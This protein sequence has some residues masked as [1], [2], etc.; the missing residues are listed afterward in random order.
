V[1]LFPRFYRAGGSKL[2]AARIQA[3]LICLIIALTGGCARDHFT[4]GHGD[5]GKFILHQAIVCGGAPVTT[6]ALPVISGRWR[7]S[8]DK[9]GVD[10]RMSREQFPAVEVFLRQAFGEPQNRP[11]ATVDDGI[12]GHYTLSSQGGRIL[13]G[14]DSRKT[15]I[16]IIRPR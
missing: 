8:E 3:S 2:Y 16:I 15:Q 10:I 14:Y 5:V 13:F 4:S 6:N 11:E 12:L 9:V 7:Y 1:A